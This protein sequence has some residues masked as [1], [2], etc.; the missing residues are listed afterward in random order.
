MNTTRL[1][2]VVLAALLVPLAACGQAAAPERAATPT[3]A[4]PALEE[5]RGD[6][7][8]VPTEEPDA[9]SVDDSGG[10]D[11]GGDAAL[12]LA[13]AM[14]SAGHTVE[15]SG[16]IQ[17]PF[18]SVGGQLFVVNGEEVQLFVYPDAAAAA[19]EAAEIAPGA[20]SVG[21]TMLSW[22]ATPHFY[23]RDRLI[24]L[25][26]GEQQSVITA[27]EGAFGS[28]IA[29]GPAPLPLPTDTVG[30]IGNAMAAGNY[31]AIQ[32]HMGDPFIIGYWQ[33]EGQTLTQAQAVEQLRLNLLPNPTAVTFVRDRSQF[34]DL[35][36]IDPTTAFGPDVQIVDLVYSQ[37][38]GQSGQ[39]EAILTIA[40]AADG[41]LY[42]HGMI[43]GRFGGSS[44]E[45]DTTEA[46][47][48]LESA[49]TNND[50][51]AM[52]ALMADPFTIGY[53]QSEGQLLSPAEATE[54]LRLNLL[55]DPELVS[56]THDPAFF[57]DLG[58]FD[59]AS[60]FGPDVRIVGLIYSQD[61]GQE[62]ND[63]AIMA[64][65]EAAD[66]R[67]F[68]HGIIYA[69]G[70]FERSTTYVNP[71]AGYAVDYP[72]GW[73]ILGEAVP[74]A[75]AYTIILQSFDPTV[76]GEPVPP[77]QAKLD[78]TS[79]PNDPGCSTMDAMRARLEEQ[80]LQDIEI[81]EEDFITL[82]SG[83]PAIRMQILGFGGESSLLLTEIGGKGLQVSG[84][85]DLAA[86]DPI[87]Q[88]L[89]PVGE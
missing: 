15:P 41:Q 7:E 82:P 56:F 39:E 89:R 61:W 66:G 47:A 34:P 46:R 4:G 27:L 81:L 64:I 83:L 58:G 68:W 70:G 20:G 65:S 12:A 2:F 28:A 1:L 5:F 88:T 32:A 73:R 50:Y 60:A 17:Q 54:Q 62:E 9:A 42:W 71:D 23:S 85:G 19:A 33:S 11:S 13:D 87:V 38:W 75:A 21:T 24:A 74:E 55:P 59:P 29:E 51:T 31:E 3:A 40:Q 16:Q 86:F 57:P 25:Y 26:V 37:G 6:T 77:D 35:G 48:S 80:S 84:F 45:N 8:A 79:C 30:A 76:G 44:P 67:Q 10:D 36:G 78:F 49:L 18:F 63:E 52:Q 14:R 53:W 72:A 43:Y 22:V 69:L